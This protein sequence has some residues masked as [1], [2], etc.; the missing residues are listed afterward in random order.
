MGL[1]GA[2]AISVGIYFFIYDVVSLSVHIY[3]SFLPLTDFWMVVLPILGATIFFMN[4]V[5]TG[6][7][8]N[9]IN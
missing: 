4:K 9:I 8:M 7:K 6:K 1:V 5:P 2:S 3:R